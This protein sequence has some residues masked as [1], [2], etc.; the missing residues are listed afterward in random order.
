MQ[1][2]LN[3][4]ERKPIFH[5]ETDSNGNKTDRIIIPTFDLYGKEVGYGNGRKRITT[6]AY[7]I[8][9]SPKILKFSKIYSAKYLMKET[10][11]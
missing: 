4:E 10:P 1:I 7:E 5:T 11:I 6:H 2:D 8:Y 3:D 9:T